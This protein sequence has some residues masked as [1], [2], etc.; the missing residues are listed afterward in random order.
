MST[1][2]TSIHNTQNVEDVLHENDKL[3][4]LLGQTYALL[5]LLKGCDPSE[6]QNAPSTDDQESGS[7]Y[8]FLFLCELESL[9]VCQEGFLNKAAS[10]KANSRAQ[11]DLLQREKDY[12]YVSVPD[13]ATPGQIKDIEVQNEAIDADRALLQNSVVAL[14]QNASVAMAEANAEVNKF[15]TKTSRTTAYLRTL[16]E[17]LE[18]ICSILKR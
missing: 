5:S 11:Q 17:V 18:S 4:S 15:A 2:V 16:N 12:K 1:Q 10:L 6:G 8:D 14:R 7:L 9:Q 13:K 3:R